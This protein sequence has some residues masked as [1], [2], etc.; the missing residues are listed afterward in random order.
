MREP[1]ASSTERTPP[2]RARATGGAALHA[3]LWITLGGWIG[4]W[5]VFGLVVAP[6]AFRVLPSSQTAGSLIGPVLEMLQLFGSAAGALLAVIARLQGRGFAR[7]ALPLAMGAAC[8]YS[9][10]GL[11]AQMA[12]I[13]EAAFGP[14]GSEALAARFTQLHRISVCI[15]VAVGISALALAGLHARDDTSAGR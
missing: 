1:A 14:Q 10:F 6:T 4:A 5:L 11:S 2:L 9:Q 15:F 3:A 8:F 12:E 7:W 13:Q